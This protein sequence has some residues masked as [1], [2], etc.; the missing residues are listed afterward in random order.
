MR[1]MQYAARLGVLTLS[2]VGRVPTLPGVEAESGRPIQANR[3]VRHVFVEICE[4]QQQFE[5]AVPLLGIWLACSGLEVLDDRQGI[6]QQPFNVSALQGTPLPASA[7]GVVGAQ[8]RLVKKM[9]ETQLLARQGSGD[10]VRARCPL[11]TPGDGGH[12]ITTQSRC[13]FQGTRRRAYHR[14]FVRQVR[15]CEK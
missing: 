5:H 15:R 7:E 1:E 14:L 12:N 4:D 9:V 11:A 8:K 3:M 6:R 13:T 2:H 10:R